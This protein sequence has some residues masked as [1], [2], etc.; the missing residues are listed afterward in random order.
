M[1]PERDVG[2]PAFLAERQCDGLR[3]GDGAV[4]D[5]Q[6]FDAV[7]PD[8]NAGGEG[9]VGAE[10]PWLVADEACAAR[11]TAIET[12]RLAALDQCLPEDAG[13]GGADIAVR[14][15]DLQRIDAYLPLAP[16]VLA[17]NLV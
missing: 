2:D 11:L 3:L 12:G 9:E 5:Q 17:K 15:D 6:G 14:G 16:H 8:G 10:Q 1:G 13:I 7:G 4:A